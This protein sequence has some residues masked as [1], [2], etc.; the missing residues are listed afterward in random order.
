MELFIESRGN[1]ANKN[2]GTD[3]VFDS[4]QLDIQVSEQVNQVM[5]FQQSTSTSFIPI[6][7]MA[8]P[9]VT[10]IKKRIAK[11]NDGLDKLKIV[12]V[13]VNKSSQITIEGPEAIKEIISQLL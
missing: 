3:I 5:R 9:D 2:R 11:I 6:F 8:N 1:Q 10:S 13:W 12:G 7:F 4:S